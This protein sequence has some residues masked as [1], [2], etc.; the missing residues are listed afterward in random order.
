M[1]KILVLS[2][3]DSHMQGHGW[4]TA[5]LLKKQGH[6]VC[7][8]TLFKTLSDTEHYFYDATKRFGFAAMWRKS[9]PYLT[10]LFTGKRPDIH[11]FASTHLFGVSAK[12]ILAKCPFKPDFIDLKWTDNFLKDKTIY[13]LQK[14]TNA[15]II[16]SFVDQAYLAACHYP[17]SCDNWKTG[18]HHCKAL[19]INKW[20]ATRCMRTRSKYWSDIKGAVICSPHEDVLVKDN[21]FLK[22]K[23]VFLYVGV[24]N[25]PYYLPKEEARQ[26]FGINNNDFVLFAGANSFKGKRKGMSVF[27]DASRI[28]ADRIEKGLIQ[29]DRRITLLLIGNGA[30]QVR[31]DN[32]LNIVSKPF[33]P[34]EH[35]F[36]AYYACDIHVSPSLADS[37]PM[38]VNYSFAC[39]RPVVAFPIG[40]AATLIK[41]GE[42]G[43]LAEYGNA[44]DLADKIISLYNR[45][46]NSISDMGDHCLDLLNSYK[47]INDP[48]YDYLRK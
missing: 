35:F 8:V 39:K 41:D 9:L 47:G 6:E 4:H 33:L 2:T 32:R 23:K 11:A 16:F 5:E 24:I 31:F 26:F 14:L 46:K 19:R 20:L 28:I 10:C 44:I 15:E 36:K 30:G 25:A 48:F 37:G 12:R 42:T 22:N 29:Q 1:A 7:L 3:H 43:F 45:D 40:V 18:C 34:S 17:A 21:P 13:D 38:M 27:A